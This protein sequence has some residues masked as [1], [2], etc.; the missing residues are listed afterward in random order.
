MLDGW[1]NADHADHHAEGLG[2]PVLDKGARSATVFCRATCN[3]VFGSDLVVDGT[4]GDKTQSA[5]DEA[6][7]RTGV[8]GDLAADPGASQQ[9]LRV[10]AE[11]AL[12]GRMAP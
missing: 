12:E 10:V 6:Q 3:R 5:M 7:A 9:R 1:F 2:T 8:S 4:W 11:I